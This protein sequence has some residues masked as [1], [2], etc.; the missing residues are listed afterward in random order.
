MLLHIQ[1]IAFL[2]VCLIQIGGSF[3][4]DRSKD[5]R[6]REEGE[7]EDPQEIT[8]PGAWE[9]NYKSHHDSKPRGPEAVAL[10]F[11]FLGAEQVYGVPE[12]ADSLALKSTGKGDPYRLYNLDVFE[13]EVNTN[14]ALYAAVPFV[15]AH[16][17]SQSAGVF[18]LN[19]AETWVDVASNS[20]NNVVSSI[21]NFVS[22][23]NKKPQETCSVKD[24]PILGRPKSATNEA[25]SL[26]V[27]HSI[28][29]DPHAATRN[30]S[31]DGAPPHTVACM[32]TVFE[33][34]FSKS[35][36]LS[37]LD[38]FVWRL[39]FIIMWSFRTLVPDM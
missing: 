37:S 3:S 19:T 29:E 17:T 7:P 20:D 2:D 30:V 13:Y 14:M 27:L 33:Q 21:V 24:R 8:D 22:G 39:L 38:Y 25:L 36:N 10:D 35:P 34:Y 12:H 32:S 11:S 26:D 5:L 15:I 6:R 9:E 23:S 1:F 4:L 28:V 31:Q 18:W 16:S